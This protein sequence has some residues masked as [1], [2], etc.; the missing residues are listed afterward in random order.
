M[1]MIEQR[2]RGS[3]QVVSPVSAAEVAA[4]R[5]DLRRA[6][7]LPPAVYHDPE[8]LAYELEAWFADGWVCVGRTEDI[9]LEGEYF[10]TS[11]CNENIIVVRDNDQQIRAF[12]NV[13][14]HRGATIVKDPNGRVPRFQCPYHAWVY[15]LDGALHRTTYLLYSHHNQLHSNNILIIKPSQ[16]F[17][18]YIKT[19]L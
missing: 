15:D 19:I 18:K 1:T 9:R 14:R 12:F 10:L 7:L 6:S 2:D 3:R 16:S 8:I 5:T 11:L 17:L 13:C 4:T